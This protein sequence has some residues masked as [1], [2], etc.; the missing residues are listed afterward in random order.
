[1]AYL[2]SD[3]EIER[4]ELIKEE[5]KWHPLVKSII[6]QHFL[7]NDPKKDREEAIDLCLFNDRNPKIAVRIRNYYYLSNYGNQFTIRFWVKGDFENEY[8]KLIK[9][10]VE[11]LFYGFANEANNG[12]SLSQYFIGDLR[13]FR[14]HLIKSKNQFQIVTN[15]QESFLVFKLSDMPS[16]FVLF[17]SGFLNQD[18][19]SLLAS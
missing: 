17:H 18:Q 11:Y 5:K 16:D 4:E 14:R 19:F 15:Q 8:E 3:Q 7:I 12:E 6:G 1:M 10:N 9:G 13:V 2:T